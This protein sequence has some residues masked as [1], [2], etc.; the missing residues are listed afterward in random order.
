MQAD[1]RASGR[2]RQK[3]SHPGSALAVAAALGAWLALTACGSSSE[4]DPTDGAALGDADA[5]GSAA[6]C[7][8]SQPMY[9]Q[10]VAKLIDSH[11][12]SCHGAKANYGA[13]WTLTGGYASLVAGQP[14]QRA[15]DR[16]AQAVAQKQMPPVGTPPV[17]HQ[18]LDT[19]TEW[20]SCGKMHPDH[21]KG[22]VVDKPVFSA[23]QAPPDGTPSFDLRADQFAVGEST[24]DLYQCFT[25]EAPVDGD[26]FV[27]RIEAV[28][29]R[30]EVVHHV[31]LLK[32]PAKAFPLG[33][34]GC[35]T[36]PKGSLYLYAWAPGGG[37]VQFPEGGMRIRKGERY[38]LQIH[39][40]NGA[41]LKNVVDQSGVRLWHGPPEGTEY[42]MLAPGPVAFEVPPNSTISA[43]GQCVAA[44]KVHLLAGMP[45]MHTHGSQFKVAVVRPDGSR[46]SVLDLSGWSFEMQP[47][48]NLDTWLQP[49]DRLETTCTWKNP[50]D[51]PVSVGEGT[52]D[53]MCFLFSFV[54]PPPKTAY[55]DDFLVP[56]NADV[57]YKPGLC[58][59]QKANPQPPRIAAKIAFGP[60]PTLAG[61]PLPDGHW[62]LSNST[63]VLPVAAKSQ[64]NGD[65]SLLVSRGQA[66][67]SG[68][69]LTLDT[70]VRLLIQTTNGAG[71]D[72]TD[73]LSRAGK[74]LESGEPGKANWQT[75]CGGTGDQSVRYGLSGDVL[76]V[77]LLK[78]VNQFTLPAVYTF[79]RK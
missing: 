18:A 68:G 62:E 35:A 11:C 8:P 66:W 1:S 46:Q 12:G 16:I 40:N 27:R 30:S 48:Y 24:L 22:L 44:E 28:L 36:M 50:G 15:V 43:S 57:D 49:G 7:V 60:P 64:V 79:V 38:V 55:C 9:D 73:H 52:E 37:A 6:T 65:A 5:S 76:T 77:E 10:Q 45:H 21:S 72:T 39:Y 29:D 75:D 71:V 59:G 78:P 63:L 53:E 33:R 20:A 13:G 14:G 32:D 61:G 70:A 69:R 31:V 2:S 41:A 17:P 26:R 4:P 34:K 58:A 51:E 25:F 54:T 3:V 19:L 67:T 42:G 56:A 23:P 74:L 47:F